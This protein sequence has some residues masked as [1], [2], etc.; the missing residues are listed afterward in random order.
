MLPEKIPAGHSNITL[1]LPEEDT[2]TQKSLNSAL[3]LR[4]TERQCTLSAHSNSKNM[5]IIT[6]VASPAEVTG[7]IHRGKRGREAFAA[8]EPCCGSLTEI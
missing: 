2:K 8:S 6:P 3:V 4:N 1:C 5:D 7:S